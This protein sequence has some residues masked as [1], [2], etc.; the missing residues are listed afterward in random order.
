MKTAPNP[1]DTWLMNF[2]RV[3]VKPAAALLSWSPTG[4]DDFHMP[5]RKG[6]AFP[7]STTAEPQRD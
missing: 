7:H 1:G 2:N 3:E 6:R 4:K 5:S